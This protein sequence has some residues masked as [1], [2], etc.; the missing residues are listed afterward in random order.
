MHLR[1]KVGG[2]CTSLVPKYKNEG[3]GRMGNILYIYK[4]DEH[5]KEDQIC[6]SDL[7]AFS[8][9]CVTLGVLLLRMKLH[10]NS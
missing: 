10:G 2:R 6:R 4:G 8:K 7:G 9:T 5:S 1:G 3:H